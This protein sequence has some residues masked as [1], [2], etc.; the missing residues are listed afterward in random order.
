MDSKTAS[1]K[2]RRRRQTVPANI[3][4]TNPPPLPGVN[5]CM[6][7]TSTTMTEGE[8]PLQPNL[9]LVEEIRKNK[10][11]FDSLADMVGASSADPENFRPP[12]A[13]NAINSLVEPMECNGD[14]VSKA[15]V[16]PTKTSSSLLQTCTSTISKVS[17][18]AMQIDENLSKDSLSPKAELSPAIS[19]ADSSSDSAQ[20]TEM[21]IDSTGDQDA[22][23]AGPS[24]A[25]SSEPSVIKDM[26]Q[27]DDLDNPA[28]RPPISDEKKLTE[29]DVMLLVEL[30]YLPY[31]HGPKAVA[32]LEEVHWLKT[33]AFS[34]CEAKQSGNPSNKVGIKSVCV[35][36]MIGIIKGQISIAMY[37]NVHR[38][39]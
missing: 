3:L 11:A 26:P 22:D 10:E 37:T 28:F 34:V 14:V 5:T 19:G 24:D 4:G 36:H 1:S 7:T 2:L 32:M 17:E 30:F 16:I 12:P 20:D 23:K 31:E 25:I 33:N 27:E 6:S 9:P 15:P 8:A 21:Q 39:Y 13:V 35:H 29:E 38:A 18:M